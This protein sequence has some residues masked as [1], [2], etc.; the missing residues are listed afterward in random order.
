MASFT[1]HVLSGSNDYEGGDG[2][3]STGTTISAYD[4]NQGG[5]NRYAFAEIDTTSLPSNAIIS[6]VDLHYYHDGY[7]KV[8]KS[9]TYLRVISVIDSGGTPSQVYSSTA[10][11]P[12]PAW[13]TLSI[14]NQSDLDD[15]MGA[16]QTNSELKFRFSVGSAEA[17]GSRNW[18]IR[19]YEYTGSYSAY[20]VVTYTLPINRII[21]TG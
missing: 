7:T 19:A 20:V 15:I 3:V 9:T 4:F 11:A 1:G 10:T 21:I 8:G 2:A 13:I 5:S 17:T 6:Q 16:H 12:T 14:T 18:E